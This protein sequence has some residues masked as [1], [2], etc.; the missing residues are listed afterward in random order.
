MNAREPSKRAKELD[1][2]RGASALAVIVLHAG[3]HPLTD[4]SASGHASWALLVPNVMARFAVPVFMILSGMGLTLSARRDE[5]Y[6]QF[7]RRRLSSI[8]PAYVAWSLIYAWLFPRHEMVSVKTLLAGLLTGNTS[9]HLYFVPAVLQLYILYPVLRSFARS[10]WGVVGCCVLSWSM[11]WLSGELTSTPLGA[12]VDDV[13]PL[14]WL[15]FFVLGIWFA[16]A[17][18]S[19]PRLLARAQA[20]AP[21]VAIAALA[22]MVAIVQRVISQTADID[23]ALGAAEPLVLV[24]SVGVLLWSTNVSFGDGPIVRF[25]TFVSDH[26][27]AVYLSHIALLRVCVLSL[28]AIAS[29]STHVMMFSVSVVL[30]IPLALATAVLSDGAKRRYHLL[31]HSVNDV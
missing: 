27:Y 17:R 11:I 23:V 5:G 10:P 25:L 22:C 21:V 15:G 28:Q 1:V 29:E 24:Y 14:R 2:L 19:A 9:N 16:N 30:G 6:P 18:S 20:I 4:Q 31:Q 13:L 7:V 3:S 8:V 12:F 26:S